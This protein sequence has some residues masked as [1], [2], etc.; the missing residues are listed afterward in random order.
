MQQQELDPLW[1]EGISSL[2]DGEYQ[3]LQEPFSMEDL[4]GYANQYAVRI[5]D[6]LETLF[7]MAS[8]GAWQYVDEKGVEQ[9]LDEN[10][11]NAMY[12]KGRP[13]D[14]DL[15][16]FPGLWKPAGA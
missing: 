4:R 10:A 13:D 14:A 1:D 3:R 7:L 6:I 16:A 9:E 8:Y 11:L 2:L 15:E 5:G 12:A